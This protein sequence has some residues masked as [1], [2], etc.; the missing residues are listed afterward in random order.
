MSA[1]V[2]YLAQFLVDPAKAEYGISQLEFADIKPLAYEFSVATRPLY[3]S[4]ARIYYCSDGFDL[5][6]PPQFDADSGN[7][8]EI[9]SIAAVVFTIL[10][11][12]TVRTSMEERAHAIHKA[13][14]HNYLT[15][16]VRGKAVG[17][18]HLIVPFD[19]LP[20]YEKKKRY[21]AAEVA[22]TIVLN[23]PTYEENE[24]F[25]AS[26]M[27]DLATYHV[28]YELLRSCNSR[29]SEPNTLIETFE[30]DML[31]ES[32]LLCCVLVEGNGWR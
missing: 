23:P 27:I 3:D 31:C 13:L 24:R 29:I 26:Q 19:A 2:N 32:A 15:W 22:A 6:A 25:I 12:V 7:S 4:F 10:R 14:C 30:G 28:A 16:A 9:D 17:R 11:L 1:C 20:P 21:F 18:H 5:G 8:Y